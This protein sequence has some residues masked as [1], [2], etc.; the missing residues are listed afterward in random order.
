MGRYSPDSND[1]RRRWETARVEC[2]SGHRE[3]ETPRAVIL[4]GIRFPV[5][6]VLSR[7]RVRDI[8]TGRTAETFQCRL[9]A[10]WPVSLERSEDGS[11]RV[12]RSATFIGAAK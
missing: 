10:G 9:E 11:W 3:G 8:Q 7:E 12:R 6:E 4:G 1:P 2:Y 5:A